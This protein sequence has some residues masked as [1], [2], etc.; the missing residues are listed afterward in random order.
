MSGGPA[1]AASAVKRLRR[2]EQTLSHQRQEQM[3]S[4][5]V[6][7]VSQEPNKCCSEKGTIRIRHV[8]MTSVPLRRRAAFIYA[9]EFK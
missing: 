3:M 2:S 6:P 7:F 1:S 9:A 8:H 4:S 5:Q